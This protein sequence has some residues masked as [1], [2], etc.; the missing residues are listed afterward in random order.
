MD[1]REWPHQSR[2]QLYAFRKESDRQRKEFEEVL[3]KRSIECEQL[4]MK[5]KTT[6]KQNSEI[7]QRLELLLEIQET[8]GMPVYKLK[9]CKVCLKEKVCLHAMHSYVLHA[10]ILFSVDCTV[11]VL[12]L[13]ML[14]C[15][16][17]L[18]IFMLFSLC[19]AL[20]FHSM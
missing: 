7:E 3:K 4:R 5:L 15:T 9:V 16:I 17:G 6:Q 11:A 1:V 19:T 10:G 12:Y 8:E 13:E 2:M 20:E 14:Q 18:Y